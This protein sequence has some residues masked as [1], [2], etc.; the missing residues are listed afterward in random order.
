[1]SVNLPKISKSFFS[2][3]YNFFI[4][5]LFDKILDGHYFANYIGYS[6]GDIQV[7]DDNITDNI[8]CWYL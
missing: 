8:F 3:N 2:K 5:S 6:I 4:S 1:M 7:M